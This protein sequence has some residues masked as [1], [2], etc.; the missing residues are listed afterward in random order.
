MDRRPRGP[1]GRR[2]TRAT[3]AHASQ[4]D[5]ET[6]CFPA[7]ITRL[8]NTPLF[9][10]A[11]RHK[12]PD[13][14]QSKHVGRVALMHTHCFRNRTCLAPPF[15]HTTSHSLAH[16]THSHTFRSSVHHNCAFDSNI[17]TPAMKAAPLVF[18]AARCSP[19]LGTLASAKLLAVKT[20]LPFPV[21]SQP[22]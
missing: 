11:C 16:T 2:V 8:A 3:M 15:T 13:A 7:S 20:Q 19:P 18:F 17:Q 12:S 1:W 14:C 21:R 9:D 10:T 5:Q 4:T 22:T 6:V